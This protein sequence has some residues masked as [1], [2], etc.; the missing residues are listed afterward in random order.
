MENKPESFQAINNGFMDNNKVKVL[1]VSQ[2]ETSE[3]VRILSMERLSV[4]GISNNLR[5]NLWSVNDETVL[6]SSGFHLIIYP[7]SDGVEKIVD[8][9]TETTET[10]KGIWL[11]G[12]RRYVVLALKATKE[13][14][15][16][17]EI[18][19][20]LE[21]RS[22]AV[23]KTNLSDCN[24]LAVSS[25]G[26]Y[27]LVISDRRMELWSWEQSLVLSMLENDGLSHIKQVKNK[28]L[29]AI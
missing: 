27:I 14:K 6:F 7:I 19:D 18:I 3:F 29:L 12:N 10:I 26:K 17:V 11:M 13:L 8:F 15:I 28:Y 22:K 1:V 25:E 16:H 2:T 23:L 9:T 20:I 4:L 24:H 5:N 21:R